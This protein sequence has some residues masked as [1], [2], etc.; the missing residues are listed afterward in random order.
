MKPATLKQLSKIIKMIIDKETS[1]EQLQWMLES[2]AFPDLLDANPD[3]N[4]NGFDRDAHRKFHGLK[5][6]HLP[7]IIFGRAAMIVASTATP[8][9][10][11]NHFVVNTKKNALVKISRLGPSFI[12]GFLGK[13]EPPFRGSILRYGRLSRPSVDGHIIAELGGEAKAETTL[14]EL[15]ASMKTQ[16]KGESCL[17]PTDGSV[18][19]FY[20]KNVFGV[21]RAVEAYWDTYGW[22]V[23][24]YT[25]LDQ[26]ELSTA[27]RVFFRSPR[28]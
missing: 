15:F 25:V 7:L 16:K 28:L 21:L 12:A 24:A 2:G 3:A 6:L 5:S 11:R 17:L 9:I 26:P 19:I 1:D 27:C 23:D 22:R 14:I 4:P 20:I 8:F 10:A 18:N 13:E